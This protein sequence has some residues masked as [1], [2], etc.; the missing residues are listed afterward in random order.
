MKGTKKRILFITHLYFPAL[1]G[2]ER[3]FQRIA[4]GLSGR[5]HD[6]T[7]LTSDAL[8][9]EQ[10]YRGV[11]DPPPQLETINGVRI[12]RQSLNT[13]I[14]R[15]F[16]YF[17][18][19]NRTR[20]FASLCG[21]LVFGPHFF[22][23]FQTVLKQKFDTVI[24]GPTP[25]S[26]L[27]YGLIYKTVHPRSQLIL[28]PHLH[29]KD[30]MHTAAINIFA[31]KRATQV[32]VLTD[33]EKRYLE[34]RGIKDRRL[35]RIVN[36]VDDYL[37]RTARKKD[38]NLSDNI[39]FLGQEG[40][41]KRI[42]LLIDAMVSIW[43]NGHR[44][45]LVI[46]GARANYSVVIDKKIEALPER[47]R[48][49]ITRINDFPE[50]EK[51]RLLDN[52]RVLVNPSSYEAFGI[53]FLEAWARGK[54]VIGGRIP[55]VREIIKDGVNGFLFDSSKKGDLEDKITRFIR[56]RSLAEQLGKAGQAEV[57]DRY[58]WSK[59]VDRIE[60]LLLHS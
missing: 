57:R 31:L 22:K 21:S 17:G 25:T 56:N 10:Y 59:I 46:A 13:R 37:L 4:E 40:E 55:A 45:P 9:T 2:A 33:A 12:F 30:R 19:L 48:S 29:I 42:P 60:D 35:T 18:A 26:T 44:N 51:V 41:H 5:G 52:C 49:N 15:L 24:A 47:L 20:G 11:L 16:R 53:V 8:S 1:G 7:V 14:Y 38:E 27:F 54:P 34:E 6:V 36:G 58:V 43:E 23:Q 50:Q 32:L 39:L 28:F 3:V